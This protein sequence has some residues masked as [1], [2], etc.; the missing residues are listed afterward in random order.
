MRAGM[1]RAS[2]MTA[3]GNRRATSATDSAPLFDVCP[4]SRS[5]STGSTVSPGRTSRGASAAA[6]CLAGDGHA[7]QAHAVGR[8]RYPL[9]GR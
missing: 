3:S 5:S 2:K 6:A 7:V 1:K 8:D 9:P 4:R